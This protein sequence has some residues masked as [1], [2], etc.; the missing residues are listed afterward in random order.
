M[1]G[2]FDGLVVTQDRAVGQQDR[3]PQHLARHKRHVRERPGSL[4]GGERGLEAQG[5]R[6]RA[7]GEPWP[8]AGRGGAGRGLR[9]ARPAEPATASARRPAR[10]GAASAGPS[11]GR[12]RAA[13][14]QLFRHLRHSAPAFAG[15]RETRPG[16]PLGVLWVDGR[17]P[18]AST[19]GEARGALRSRGGWHLQG[20]EGA[21]G[22]R[23]GGKPAL[24]EGTPVGTN[25]AAGGIAAEVVPAGQGGCSVRRD[26][27]KPARGV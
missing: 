6:G 4:E 15:P 12:G 3:H 21:R 19:A 23:E 27:W 24:T 18:S 13:W 10:A 7:P 9:R 17:P 16:R 26:R 14:R 5:A 20:R 25:V 22:R 8:A 11:G 1:R 2:H